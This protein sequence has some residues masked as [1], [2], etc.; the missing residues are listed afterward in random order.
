MEY[1]IIDFI[2]VDSN[3]IKCDKYQLK[4]MYFWIHDK[5]QIQRMFMVEAMTDNTDSNSSFTFLNNDW[6]IDKNYVDDDNK[7]NV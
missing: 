7:K 4:S 3:G 5:N 6:T 2:N 1:Q